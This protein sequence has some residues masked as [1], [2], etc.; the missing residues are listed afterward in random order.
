[1]FQLTDG[2]KQ[3][4]EAFFAGKDKATVRIYLASGG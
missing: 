1:M 3:E 4:L 2:A